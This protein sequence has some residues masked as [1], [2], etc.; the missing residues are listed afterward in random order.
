LECKKGGAQQ[1]ALQEA[2]SALQRVSTIVSALF[3]QRL[4]VRGYCSRHKVSIPFFL[5]LFLAAGQS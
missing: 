5:L 2:S 4:I 1:A 3:G